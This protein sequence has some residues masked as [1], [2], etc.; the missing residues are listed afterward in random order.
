MLKIL[1]K[2]QK[3]HEK[4]SALFEEIQETTDGAE[5]TRSDLCRKIVRELEAHTGF[6]EDV[7]YPLLRYN[8]SDAED[9]IDHAYDEHAGIK[10]M[11]RRLQEA[12][13]TSEEFMDLV[14]AL[15]DAVDKHVYE[16]EREI[17]PM[18]RESIGED[19]SREM[20]RKHD[21]MA[22]RHHH[23]AAE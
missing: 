23:P 22:Q 7:F 20:A 2:L 9:M 17:F 6:E 12:D 21:H 19:Q 3:D 18:A 11:L 13:V 15:Q 8:E 16:E 4:V 1:Q 5:K 14:D 10:E